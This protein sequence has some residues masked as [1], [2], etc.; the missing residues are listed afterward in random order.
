MA[1]GISGVGL[2]PADLLALPVLVGL[3]VA[4]RRNTVRLGMVDSLVAALLFSAL[5][6]V[7]LYGGRASTLSE[8]T[9]SWILPYVLGRV[10]MT[11]IDPNRLPTLMIRLGLLCAVWAIVEFTFRWHPFTS[12]SGQIE[13]LNRWSEIQTRGAFDRS[14]AAFGHSIPLAA[15]IVLTSPWVLRSRRPLLGLVILTAGVACTLARSGFISLA[16]VV[17]MMI[18]TSTTRKRVLVAAAAGAAA[19]TYF[20]R[21]LLFGE[22]VGTEVQTSTAYRETLWQYG[23][24]QIKTLG[25]AGATYFSVDNAYLRLGLELGWIPLCLFAVLALLP[26]VAVVRRD[27]GAGEIALAA[28]SVMLLT[29]ALL[30]QWQSFVWFVAGV[31]VVSRSLRR[32]AVSRGGPEIEGPTQPDDLDAGTRTPLGEV[33]RVAP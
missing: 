12:I 8:I 1:V 2:T 23:F 29:V 25:D 3:L 6:S 10:A 28:T 11:R 32:N 19:V 31:T 4:E 17:A 5:V 15:M 9:V 26:V 20:G 16:L 24:K 33:W 27:A 7:A 18:W 30:T 21:G 14:E 13:V 22:G